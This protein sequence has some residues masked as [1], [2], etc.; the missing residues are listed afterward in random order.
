M[1]LENLCPLIRGSFTG[2]AEA[3]GVDVAGIVHTRAGVN[4]QIAGPNIRLEKEIGGLN[5]A[6]FIDN[7]ILWLLGLRDSNL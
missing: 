5:M 4:L 6:E 2:C 1:S 3:L 7:P